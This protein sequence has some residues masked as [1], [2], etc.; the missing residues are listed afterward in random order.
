M[1]Q[2]IIMISLAPLVCDSFLD[3][4]FDDLDGLE[5]LLKA[6][7]EFCRIYLMFFLRFHWGYSF[8]GKMTEVRCCCRIKGTYWYQR[9]FPL[10]TWPWHLAGERAVMS[11]HCKV[12]LHPLHAPLFLL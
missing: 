1:L 9:D 7:W 4:D 10:W 2:L 5:E 8:C 12:T 11:L 3:F 6:L